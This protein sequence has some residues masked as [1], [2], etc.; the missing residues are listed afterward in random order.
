MKASFN[1]FLMNSSTSA[2]S[3]DLFSNLFVAESNRR[4]LLQG[5]F[6]DDGKNSLQRSP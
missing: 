3:L 6:M 2:L 4:L 5:P 1:W